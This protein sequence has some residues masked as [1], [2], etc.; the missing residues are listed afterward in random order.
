MDLA[1]AQAILEL[2]HS[3]LVS[4]DED[5][6]IAHWNARAEDMF[7]LTREQAIGRDLADTIVPVR[8]RDAHRA[9]LR[10]FLATGAG[11]LLDRRIEL[12]AL[13]ADGSEFPIEL[14]VSALSEGDGWAFH[15]FVADI[16]DVRRAAEDERDG[17]L[18]ELQQALHGSE[19]RLSVTLDALAEAVTIRAPDDQLIYA[20]RAALARLGLESQELREADPR[21]LMEDYETTERARAGDRDG[22]PAV[23]QAAA[24]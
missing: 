23:G 15:A 3:A 10:S 19:Q 20:N 6:K 18:E 1:Q 21:A 9:G 13:R 12:S 11:K 22:R 24:R 5:G 14:T 7:G 2:T 16:S 8:L 17:L 4:M